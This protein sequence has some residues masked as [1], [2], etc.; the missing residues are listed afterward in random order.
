MTAYV[1]IVVEIFR[2]P[3]PVGIGSASFGTADIITVGPVIASSL[4]QSSSEVFDN[5]FEYFHFLV[6]N[7]RQAICSMNAGDKPRAEETLT[8]LEAKA[9]SILQG[10]TDPSCLRCVLTHADLH[11]HNILV[12]SDGRITAVLDWE[13]NLIQPAILG[14]DYPHWLSDEGPDDPRFADENTW[15]EASPAE[16]DKIRTQFEEVCERKLPS[17]NCLIFIF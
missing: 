2:L 13:L 7:K 17:D 8:S 5:I 6:T 4:S 9:Y 14:V 16:R 10:I 15:W 3:V 11:N 1:D 12:A